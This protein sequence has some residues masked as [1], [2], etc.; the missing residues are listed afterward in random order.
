[1]CLWWTSGERWRPAGKACP[2]TMWGARP[3]FSPAAPRDRPWRPW[4]GPWGRSGS[5][6]MRSPE[7]KIAALFCWP[8]AVAAAFWLRPTVRNRKI[9]GAV[10]PIAGWWRK[11]SF[12]AWYALFPRKGS[13]SMK[14]MPSERRTVQMLKVLGA[15]LIT[16]GLGAAGYLTSF[17]LQKR[18]SAIRSFVDGLT[19]LS[20]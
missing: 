11:G 1:M 14:S 10:R 17:L 20:S 19:L 12:P 5:L 6:W 15:L 2:N 9:C 7:R 8:G 13:G 3:T 4:C 18:A 16:G